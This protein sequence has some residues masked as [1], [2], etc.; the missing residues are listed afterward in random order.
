MAIAIGYA[1]FVA[2]TNTTINQTGQAIEGVMLIMAVYLFF[3]LSTSVF[4]N[5]YNKKIKLVER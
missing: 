3:S 5:W 4:M 1:D 2:V